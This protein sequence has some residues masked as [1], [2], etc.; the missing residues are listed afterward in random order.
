MEDSLYNILR[1]QRE[2]ALEFLAASS[3]GKSKEETLSVARDVIRSLLS[4]QSKI[5]TENN[6]LQNTLKALEED[7]KLNKTI[8]DSQ[9]AGS[10]RIKV[11]AIDKW[12][13]RHWASSID[14]PYTVEFVSDKFAEILG[15]T[16]KDFENNIFILSDLIY[17]V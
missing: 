6:E 8:F 3:S 1:E 17:I 9:P 4:V 16:K 12:T 5:E 14:S 10:Y 11:L 7:Q 13:G 2:K 15:L